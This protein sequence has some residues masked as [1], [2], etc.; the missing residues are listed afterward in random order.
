MFKRIVNL[1]SKE[2]VQL[3]RDW[4]MLTLIIV[5]PT[6]ELVLLA[7]AVSHGIS[8][9]PVGVVDQDHSEFSRQLVAAI[10]HTD[11][12]DVTAYADS[13]DQMNTWL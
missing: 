1:A 4:V 13:L 7:R 9:M 3:T 6:L 2:L 10:D 12:L 11:E 8:H 5:G